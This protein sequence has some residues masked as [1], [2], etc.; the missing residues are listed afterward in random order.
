M[1]EGAIVGGK[2]R[3]TRLLGSG[4]MGAVYEA[5]N[6]HLGKTVAIK[7]LKPELS[8]DENTAARFIHEARASAAIGHPNIVDVYDIIFDIESTDS[9]LLIVMEHLDGQS[10]AEL[11]DQQGPLDVGHAAYITCQLLS[12]LDAAHDG[13]LVHR[14]IK[15]ENLYLVETGQ[16]MPGV[17]LL[18]FGISKLVGDGSPVDRLTTSGIVLGTPYFMAPEQ[19]SGWTNLDHRIDL[20]SAG[21][22]LYECT[23]G[24][25]P[26]DG[27]NYNAVIA[28]ILS[29]GVVPPS[30]KDE[31]LPA[32]ID[33]VVLRALEKD[34]ERRY[35][36]A[37]EMLEALLPFVPE[38]AR[39]LI[40]GVSGEFS[41]TIDLSTAAS[42]APIRGQSTTPARERRRMSETP[43][44]VST[45]TIPRS[46]RTWVIALVLLFFVA[47]GAVAAVSMF[48]T[49]SATTDDGNSSE[50]PSNIAE[51]RA[52]TT[53]TQSGSE[54][55][56][57]SSSVSITLEGVP[58]DA[59][60]FLDDTRVEG[61][62]VE[63]PRSRE[64]RQLRIEALGYETWRRQITPMQSS[65]IEVAMQAEQTERTERT[66]GDSGP[67][68]KSRPVKRSNN[69]PNRRKNQTSETDPRLRK[70]PFDR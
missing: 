37:T 66:E 59:E 34:R 1:H 53:V 50:P 56:S 29:D 2:Y 61:D 70:N 47:M 19:A 18:D 16:I 36:D 20:W 38:R 17:R 46:R 3:L 4:G 32:E 24:Q 23:T 21:V 28:A 15:P 58:Q 35:D 31:N 63:I 45:R 54:T 62:A 49:G 25:L 26:F 10:L 44:L 27:P 39:D 11:L 43:T 22:L 67:S 48:S 51:E 68:S 65:L 33:D 64:P 8:D 12:A 14:D 40:P 9:G 6:I 13:G 41:A 42:T 57:A 30:V 5:R 52:N 60:V 7:V 55:D 69:R